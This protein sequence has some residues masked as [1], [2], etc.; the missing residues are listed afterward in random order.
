MTTSSLP[1]ESDGYD[2]MIRVINHL[3]YRHGL[4]FFINTLDY[5][6]ILRWY[7][8][9]I[10]FSLL[11]RSIAQVVQRRKERKKEVTGFSNFSNQVRKDFKAFMELNIGAAKGEQKENQNE[12]WEIE[13]FF[14]HYPAELNDLRAD[15]QDLFEKIKKREPVE[16]TGINEKLLTLFANDR[17]LD[18][19]TG[20]FAR[21]LAPPLRTPA[22]L[23]KYRVNY[24][25]NRFNIPAFDIYAGEE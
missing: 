21:N 11:A 3:E 23:R 14:S 1:K 6:L 24:L 20:V 22:I 19:K 2:F 18:M 12:Y 4:A 25:L 16:M 5:D 8:K 7:E 10:P 17:E 13:A 15:F 9:R